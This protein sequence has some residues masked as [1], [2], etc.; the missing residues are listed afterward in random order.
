MYLTI[1]PK[2]KPS[3]LVAVVPIARAL[4]HGWSILGNPV[5]LVAKTRRSYTAGTAFTPGICEF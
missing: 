5:G 4:H 3:L 2:A 1:E